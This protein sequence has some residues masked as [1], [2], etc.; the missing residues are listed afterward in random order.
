[1]EDTAAMGAKRPLR[2]RPRTI[3]T[4]LIIAVIF[5]GGLLALTVIQLAGAGGWTKDETATSAGMTVRLQFRAEET[6]AGLVLAARI[7]DQAGFLMLVSS[8]SFIVLSPTG[9]AVRGP[10]EAQP[11]GVFTST[12]DGQYRAV[13]DPLP[14]GSYR[15]SATVRHG[16][17]TFNPVWP[18][19]VE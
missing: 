3:R 4:T 16:Q 1:M 7:R 15:V 6:D 2:K 5:V 13:V 18:L 8:V 12:G 9:Q 11:A 10:I 19:E 14:A 17:A